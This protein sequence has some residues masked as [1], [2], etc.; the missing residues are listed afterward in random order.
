MANNS[1]HYFR[2]LDRVEMNFQ[3]VI[4]RICAVSVMASIAHAAR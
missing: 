2:H 4:I 1:P 3:L